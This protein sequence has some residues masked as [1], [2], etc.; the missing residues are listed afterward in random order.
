MA[1]SIR[2]PSEFR[3]PK[4]RRLTLHQRRR[5][6]GA[7]RSAHD[8][9]RLPA[10]D[11]PPDRHQEGLR[12]RPVRRLHRAR[13]RPPRELVA[14]PSPLLHEGDEIT[15]IEGLGTPGQLHP[16]QAAFVELR[17]LPVRLLHVGPDHVGRGAARGAVRPVGRRRAGAHERQHLPLRR[18]SEHRRRDPA[19]SPRRRGGTLTMKTFE[20]TA[21]HRSER[22]PSPRAL[23]RRRRSRA[24][25]CASSPAARRWSIS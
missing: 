8:A 16:M 1:R 24:P 14:S 2:R 22:P 15:T 3:R 25:T 17:R 13:Q 18:L 4:A 11:P 7:H 10:R 20:L 12:P 5:T 23:R 19:G 9:A 21:R 6:F